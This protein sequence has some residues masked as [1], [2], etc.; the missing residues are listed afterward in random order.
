MNMKIIYQMIYE[1]EDNI[2]NDDIRSCIDD[3]N[4]LMEINQ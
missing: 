1:H 2:S 4:K 3:L